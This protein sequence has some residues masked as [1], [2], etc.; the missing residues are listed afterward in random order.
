[1]YLKHFAKDKGII[2]SQ[3]GLLSA[4]SLNIM[5]VYFFHCYRGMP[6]KPAKCFDSSLTEQKPPSPRSNTTSAQSNPALPSTTLSLV[7]GHWKQVVFA[8]L[9]EEGAPI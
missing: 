8:H 7:L 1:M 5:V 9:K 3:G 4:Y 6:H 2:N